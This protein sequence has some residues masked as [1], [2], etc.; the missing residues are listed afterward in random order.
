MPGFQ[1]KE[2][3]AASPAPL[4][5]ALAKG[6]Q[7]AWWTA[8][9]RLGTRL[10]ERAEW[11]RLAAIVRASPHFDPAWYVAQHPELAASGS[12]PA[13]HYV[14]VGVTNRFDPGPGFGTREYL[15]D[16]PEAEAAGLNPLVHLA[17]VQAAPPSR[18]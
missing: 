3:C 1:N 16:H 7:L 10:A 17:G 15:R 9:M 18:P 6:L 14:L 8:T 2:E 12:D 11:R 13:L 5:R 4:A